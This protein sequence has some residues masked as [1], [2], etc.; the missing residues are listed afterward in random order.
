MID[1]IIMQKIIETANIVEVISEF[2]TLKKRG[3]NYVALCPFHKEKTPSFVV[4]ESKGIFKC[5]GCGKAGN[6]VNFLVQHEGFSYTQALKWLANRYNIPIEEKPLSDEL[7]KLYNEREKLLNA[8]KIAADFFVKCLWNTKEGKTI[9]L[10]YLLERKI[11]EDLIKKFG[12][13]YSPSDNKAFYNY[14]I[15]HKLEPEILIKAGLINKNYND[16]FSGRIIFPIYSIGGSIIGFSGRLI[17]NKEGSPKYINSPE[18]EIFIKGSNLYG[19]IQ[20]KQSIIKHDK[21]YLVEGNFDVLAMH[22][23]G[24][25]NTIATLGT[26]LTENHVSLI[27]RFTKNVTL[28]FDGD[29]A[30]IK[31][32]LKNID[33]LLKEGMYVKAVTLPQ[34][35]DPDSLSKKLCLLDFQNYIL[36]NEEDFLDFKLKVLLPTGN[37][38][39]IKKAIISKDII[40]SLALINDSILREIYIKTFSKKIGID[41]KTIIEQIN[42]IIPKSFKENKQFN[43][44]KSP[45]T[46]LKIPEYVVDTFIEEIEFELLRIIINYGNEKFIVNIENNPYKDLSVAE[47]II[48]ELIS[49]NLTFNN[50]IYK[51]IFEK[52]Y[53]Q[54]EKYKYI[55]VDLLKYDEDLEVQETI[56]KLLSVPYYKG[57]NLHQSDVLY[58]KFFSK[59]KIKMHKENDILENIVFQLLNM[60]KYQILENTLS[61]YQKRLEEAEK[62]NVSNEEI[63]NILL[64][65]NEINDLKKKIASQMNIVIK[66]SF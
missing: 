50:Q 1:K 5:F 36:N 17:D 34:N 7:I 44:N 62:F 46:N 60:Y 18:T 58:S 14:A 43:F 12:I 23:M 45:I 38:D 61:K 57:S 29:D 4:S 31:A 40:S 59:L 11:P 28:I 51:K 22:K 26:A 64:K 48:Y 2:V 20:A 27:K 52:I 42:S 8:N 66:Y 9:G 33:I 30:G 65:I 56:A 21:C 39:P 35:E 3:S 6:V 54:I 10:A 13:G 53:K 47:I 55:D 19:I 25:E 37:I 24:L 63:D 16:I 15:T 49:D 41:E 32:S